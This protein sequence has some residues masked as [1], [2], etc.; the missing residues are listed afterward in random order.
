VT[1]FFSN[2]DHKKHEDSKIRAYTGPAYDTTRGDYAYLLAFSVILAANTAESYHRGHEAV[3]SL[4]VQLPPERDN[5]ETERILHQI[6]DPQIDERHF[7]SVWS[8]HGLTY[9]TLTIIT[10]DHP[11]YP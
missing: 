9:A 7:I 2:E 8:S 3:A 6:L 1:R 11:D 5:N 10:P 4:E